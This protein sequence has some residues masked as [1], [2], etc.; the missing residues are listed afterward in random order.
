KVPASTETG[1][2]PREQ[3]ATTENIGPYLKKEQR[4]PRGWLTGRMPSGLSPRAARRRPALAGSDVVS[5]RRGTVPQSS[6]RVKLG[7]SRSLAD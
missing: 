1:E 4:S 5:A 7:S 2:T 6:E 3:G